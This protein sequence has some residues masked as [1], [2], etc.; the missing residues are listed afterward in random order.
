VAAFVE[1]M[2][3]FARTTLPSFHEAFLDSDV[4]VAGVVEKRIAMPSPFPIGRRPQG[5][6]GFCSTRQVITGSHQGFINQR[7]LS[8]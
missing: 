4:Q 7:S 6:I 8:I 5:F 2:K 3:A 1:R